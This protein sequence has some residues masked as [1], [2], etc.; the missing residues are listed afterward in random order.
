MKEK[1]GASSIV[2]TFTR[3]ATK[4]FMP[5][6]SPCHQ[7]DQG[8]CQ[9]RRSVA[10]TNDYNKFYLNTLALL[11]VSNS[12][13]ASKQVSLCSSSQPD[14]GD[15]SRGRTHTRVLVRALTQHPW[16]S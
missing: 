4:S 11:A 1:K 10:H 6:V 16:R 15:Q 14:V 12:Q 8:S 5:S 13:L 7:H 3:A 9:Y 2:C